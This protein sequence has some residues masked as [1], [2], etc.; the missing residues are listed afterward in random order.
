MND[1]RTADNDQE[2][3]YDYEKSLA[4]L[5]VANSRKG[6]EKNVEEWIGTTL[7]QQRDCDDIFFASSCSNNSSLRCHLI[8]LDLLLIGNVLRPGSFFAIS[9]HFGPI[10]A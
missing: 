5:C 1:W 9:A 7:S 6:K 2:G 4:E 10:S 8:K 3:D